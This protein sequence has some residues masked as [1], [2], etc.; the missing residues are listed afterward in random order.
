MNSDKKTLFLRWG[1]SLCFFVLAFLI[2]Y[3]YIQNNVYW[4]IFTSRDILRAQ[5]WLKGQFF[6]PGPEMSGGTNLPGPFFYFLL[7]PPLLF[8]EDI[9]SQSLLW[10]I[11]WL[12]LTW[13]VAFSFLANIVKQRESLI[14]FLVT[15]ILSIGYTVLFSPLDFAWNPGFAILF[16]ILALIGLYYWRETGK[17]LYLYLSGLVVALGIQVHLLVAIHIVTVI[18]FFILDKRKRFLPIAFFLLLAC[19]P[20]LLYNILDLFNLIEDVTSQRYIEYYFAHLKIEFFSKRSIRNIKRIYFSYYTVIPFLC[21]LFLTFFRK[22]QIKKW[23]LTESIKNLFVMT[24]VP[25]FFIFFISRSE[26]YMYLI[27]VFLIL[28]FSKYYDDLMPNNPNK[29]LNYLSAYGFVAFFSILF[30]YTYHRSFPLNSLLL[31]NEEFSFIAFLILLLIFVL[32]I[33]NTNWTKHPGKVGIFSVML[34]LTAQIMITKKPSLWI[35]HIKEIV[36]NTHPRHRDLH[37]LITQI[38]LETNWLPKEAM[39]RLYIIGFH[40]EVSLFSHYEMTK[41]IVRKKGNPI[42]IKSE[43][44]LE[45]SQG[46]IIIQHLK[47]FKNY[48]QKDWKEYLSHSSLLSEFL[49]REIRE[50]KILIQ[51]PKLH[52]SYWLIPYKITTDSIF[53]EGFSNVGQAYYWEESAWLKN[54]S[55]TQHFQDKNGLYYCLVLPGYL[56]R[57]GVEVQLSENNGAIYHLNVQFFGPLIGGRSFSDN[58]DGYAAWSDVQIKLLC[59]KF[60]FKYN[61]PSVGVERRTIQRKPELQGQWFTAPLNLRIPIKKLTPPPEFSDKLFSIQDFRCEKQDIREV[62]LQFTY[63]HRKIRPFQKDVLIPKKIKVVWKLVESSSYME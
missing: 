47:R 15:F 52:T 27:P 57:A 19:F 58:I 32:I 56:Q 51:T 60:S 17:N 44:L 41:E 14:F 10:Y 37:P 49:T 1:N 46:Y 24:A 39:K 20:I 29:K 42:R 11:I 4:D 40:S 55:S 18:L 36:S 45:N 9:Y 12:A 59:G 38:Y 21:L 8:G 50:G 2:F 62:E 5:G 61:M 34:C 6:W 53:V 33:L 7:F 31:F 63:V 25:C 30:F 23:P 48:S 22:K 13:T 28:F 54:C 26:W 16:H 43:Q 35:P 3:L